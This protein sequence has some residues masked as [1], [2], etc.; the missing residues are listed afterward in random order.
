MFGSLNP[1]HSLFVVSRLSKPISK[2]KNPQ[3]EKQNEILIARE[4]SET[5]TLGSASISISFS[6]IIFVKAISADVREKRFLEQSTNLMIPHIH[7]SKISCVFVCCFGKS[8]YAEVDPNPI[9]DNITNWQQHSDT[10]T[11][12]GFRC[13]EKKR[14]LP[15]AYLKRI[16]RKN[17]QKVTCLEIAQ[18][19]EAKTTT[20][21]KKMWHT[22]THGN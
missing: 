11:A 5:L 18:K 12:F 14:R 13:C 17:E 7:G 16:I 8:V 20:K 6:H 1:F 2:K 21:E 9:P 19:Y 10:C 15:T 3:K 22:H 4:F